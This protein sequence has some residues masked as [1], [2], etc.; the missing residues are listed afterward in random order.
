MGWYRWVYEDVDFEDLEWN[1]LE[2][3][4]RPLDI[5]VPLQSTRW[6]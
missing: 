5:I 4:L 1:E 2:E 6:E 3:V